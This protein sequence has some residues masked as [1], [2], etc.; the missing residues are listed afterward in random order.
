[1]LKQPDIHMYFGLNF[2]NPNTILTSYQ[3]T[4]FVLLLT[5][6]NNHL[7]LDHNKSYINTDQLSYLFL[8]FIMFDNSKALTNYLP[9]R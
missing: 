8:S 3:T 4:Y 6:S 9:Q 5:K 1:M 2:L 7:I